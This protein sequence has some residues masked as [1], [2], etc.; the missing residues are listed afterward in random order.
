MIDRNS[1][2]ETGHRDGIKEGI[3][4]GKIE[5]NIEGKR[6]TAKKYFSAEIRTTCAY[7]C[8][9]LKIPYSTQCFATRVRNSQ[10]ESIF[11]YPFILKSLKSRI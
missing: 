9:S 10:P 3:E 8:A 1:L 7:Q 2:F 6:E 4:K 5:G 11:F